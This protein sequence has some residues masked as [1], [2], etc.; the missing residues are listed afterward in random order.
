[1]ELPKDLATSDWAAPR[2]SPEQLAYASNDVLHLH[3]LRE[4]LE[5]ELDLN[6]LGKVAE[7]EMQLLPVVV[8][9]EFNGVPFD[10]LRAG[11]LLRECEAK[12][13][14][15]LKE[16]QASLGTDFNPN[17]PAQVK[18]VLQA[19]G[20]NVDDT[21]EQTLAA[22]ADPLARRILAYRAA[23]SP[24]KQIHTL[25]KAA[26]SDGRIHG[27]FNPT[28]ADTGRFTSQ[29]PNLQ[30]ISRG[31]LRSCIVAPQGAVLVVADYSQVEL[32]IAAEIAGETRMLEA[33]ER[34][35]DL[36]IRTAALVLE[37]LETDVTKGD[38]Q[39]AKAVNF[40]LLYGQYPKGLVAYA[41]TN[42]GVD[43]ALDRAECIRRKFFEGYPPAPGL[44]RGGLAQ[45][46]ER[47]M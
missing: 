2:L 43:L 34:G 31:K 30:N 13:S 33:F 36:H 7:M 12:Q 3:R 8:D 26:G 21:A 35:E 39:L 14:E 45:G 5:R 40:G 37:R 25:L 24:V 29:K 44:A 9:M 46:Q 11:E 23:A 6:G 27:S 38:R 1:M 15:L 16:L 42:Y 32:R 19:G 47:R 4:A 22:C 17:S 18:Q 41:R 28:G 10:R 20:V